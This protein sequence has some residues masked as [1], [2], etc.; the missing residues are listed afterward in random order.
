MRKGILEIILCMLLL[1]AAVFPAVAIVK[2]NDR[3][4]QIS[5]IDEIYEDNGKPETY[6]PTGDTNTIRINNLDMNF[7][8]SMY[9]ES[10]DLTI[11][12]DP[13]D[14]SITIEVIDETYYIYEGINWKLHITVY[15][16]PPQEKQICIWIDPETLPPGAIFPE[17]ECGYSEVTATL[18]W[19]PYIGQAGVYHLVFYIGESCYE[20]FGY[21]TI[22]VIVFPLELEPQETY[23]IFA[24][25]QWDLE[26]TVRWTPPQP[27]RLI[28]LWV[29]VRTMPVGST[30]TPCHCEY[31]SV[32]SIFSWRPTTEQE[33]RYLI[34]FLIGETC[35]YYRYL[36]PIEVVV[37]YQQE[38]LR[39]E[40]LYQPVQTVYPDDPLYGNDMTAWI[41]PCVWNCSLDMVAG[42]NT[43]IFGYPYAKRNQIEI[44][45]HNNYNQQKT[46]SFVFKIYPDNKIIWTSDPVTMNPKEKRT[47]TYP[48]PL[49]NQPFQW[50][51]WGDTPKVEE[52]ELIL[53]L[54]PDPPVKPPAD[55]RCEQITVHA[56]VKYTHDLSVLFLPFTFKDGPA[57]PADLANIA[58]ATAFDTWRWNTLE[59]WWNAI[60]PVRERGLRTYRNWLG[61]LQ[62]NLSTSSG[63]TVS[64]AASYQTL[65]R[66]EQLE[67]WNQ[68]FTAS[69]AL[70]WMK[71]YDRIVW[72]IH[73][74]ILH[75]KKTGGGTD[76][77][78]GWAYV[79]SHT[80]NNKYGV[81]VNWSTRTKTAPH[82]I[83]HTYGLID[84]YKH[85]DTQSDA[86]GY[87]VN[88]KIDIITM[89]DL[90]WRTYPIVDTWIKKP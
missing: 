1:T 75:L 32:T 7:D 29:D 90:M 54:S 56:D 21:F 43:Y 71:L 72:L 26:L 39:F 24:D 8:S 12:L 61:N 68:L 28:C 9:A 51:H 20:P 63:K 88:K 40:C 62:K 33:G 86:V 82:E 45:V 65:T 73:P 30:F 50:D 31:G 15:Y 87:W 79:S 67:I 22:T 80:S 64:D 53:Y 85:P 13:T 49:P 83:S 44:M 69:A 38:G 81:L 84:C 14:P 57:L 23:E 3:N 36:L 47:F 34:I 27:E 5:I 42:K 77:G 55:C 52:G 16:D 41:N 70:S 4:K 2:N 10:D 19:T 6:I 89:K 17:C 35:G 76:Y 74:D 18:E 78:N 60:Y 58:S 46:F 11:A 48:A 59:P 37:T 25:E 66:S